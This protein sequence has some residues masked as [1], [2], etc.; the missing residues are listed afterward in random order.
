MIA[1]GRLT[2]EPATPAYRNGVLALLAIVYAINFIDRQIVSVLALD[3]KRDL[4]LSDADLG[5][6]YGTA[7]GVFYALFGIPMGRLADTWNRVRLISVGLAVWSAMTALSGLSRTG[8][9]L[10][11][12]RVGV[13]IGEATASPG[14]Y[15]LIS[16]YFPPE[17]RASALAVY[18][19]GMYIGA[20]ASLFLGAAIVKFWNAHFPNGWLGLV[21]WQAAFLIVGLPGLVLA[22]VVASLREP[23]RGLSEG[24]V[25]PPSERPFREF[26]N[27]L[28]T[29]LPPLSLIG[30]A[31]RG[32]TAFV[33]NVVAALAIAAIGWALYALTGNALQWS[34]FGVGAYAIWSWASALR[35]RDPGAFALTWGSKAFVA[36]LVAFGLI[37]FVNYALIFWALPYAEQALGADKATAGLIIGGGGAAGGFLGL[38][39]GGRAAD[40]LRRGNPA[41]RVFVLL[42]GA[43]AP[44]PLLA[45]SF[46]TTHLAVFYWLY[47]PMTLLSST[48]LAAAAATSQDLVLPRMR[49]LATAAFFLSIT[50]VGLAL[51]PYTVGRISAWTGD[52]G[53]AVLSLIAVMPFSAFAIVLLYRW[54][55]AAV[56]DRDARAAAVIAAAAR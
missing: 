36:L 6:L 22:L 19:S 35:Q 1:F 47:F 4:G 52:L 2:D 29:M 11:A 40:Y 39:L 27:E 8:G 25:V 16:D 54:L 45:V 18:S 55:P 9:Q 31:R 37:S 30:A 15:S 48:G 46:T 49:G 3:L 41:G 5:F 53:T 20:G 26:W 33:T 43:L 17:K 12:A 24:I 13:G 10:M 50:M 38:N 42:F 23:I 7:F 44:L 14:A 28:L 51:G 32:T 34:A 21:G 56:R